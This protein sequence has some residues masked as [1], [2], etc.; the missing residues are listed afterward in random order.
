[1]TQLTV[2]IAGHIDHG[3][4]SLVKALTGKNTDNLKEE[5]TRG[6]TI[7]I[8][9]AH[10]NENISLIDVPGHEKFIKNM[11]SGV[12]S[13]DIA[14]LVIAADDG[15]MPQT[16]EH[17]EILRFLNI[18][19]GL[20]VINKIDLVDEEW[21]S[22]VEL[23]VKDFFKDT[24]FSEPEIFKVSSIKGEGIN[25]LKNRI[26]DF[27]NVNNRYDRGISRMFVDRVFSK[28]GFGTI[29]TGTVN[30][31]EIKVGDKLKILP[32]N[33]IVKVRG[34]H[35]H[36]ESI[37]IIEAG[38]RGAINISSLDKLNIHRGHHI[39]NEN[40]FKMTSSAII[41]INSLSKKSKHIIK[42]NQRI[43]FH[44]GT[45]EVM[46]RLLLTDSNINNKNSFSGII[47]FEK[48]IIASFK[49]R[50]IIRSYSPVS[51]IA[52]GFVL[53]IDIYG[54]WSLNKIYA[55]KLFNN[56]NND[57]NLIIAIIEKS[58]YKPYNLNELSEKLG[59]AKEK[60]NNYL[61]DYKIF[62]FGNKKNPWIITEGQLNS[63]KNI[64]L[65]FIMIFIRKIIT[66]RD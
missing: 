14:I 58:I 5:I 31:G 41:Y 27:K 59:L 51:T 16:I 32:G 42:H 64:I 21:L 7:N 44:L 18:K 53:D 62:Y 57:S 54:K 40:F 45:Q 56:S 3:K 35:S 30:S 9:F 15:I 19:S 38:Y 29:L 6:M 11:V 49:D 39:S 61:N 47:K 26:I 1:M 50:F 60:I 4:T 36:D 48:A 17:F 37:D 22:I 55:K 20:I 23:E 24:L 66:L 65:D 34:L 13:I 33:N 25:K 43:R 12:S 8:G 28:T 2:G 63:I 10:L 52:G 46:A